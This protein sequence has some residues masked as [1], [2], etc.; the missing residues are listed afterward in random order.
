MP[1]LS[2]FVYTWPSGTKPIDFYPWIN[3]LSTQEQEEF[4]LADIRQKEFRQVVIDQG[5]LE[6][7]KDGYVWKDNTAQK[8]NKPNDPT[9]SV[10]WH[11]WQQET[12]VQITTEQTE[13]D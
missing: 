5:N 13:I 9:W 12:G 8:Q 10:Y 3:T 4:W 11:R 7:V 6:V 1:I 2:K